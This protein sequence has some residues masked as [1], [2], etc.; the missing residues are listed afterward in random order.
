[1]NIIKVQIIVS[2]NHRASRGESFRKRRSSGELTSGAAS[3]A[4]PPLNFININVDDEI[5]VMLSLRD[6]HNADAA[7]QCFA[8][9]HNLN[10]LARSR[11]IASV[12]ICLAL[13]FSPLRRT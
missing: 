12:K 2:T 4:L 5:A 7:F 13:V 1:L 8:T 11:E 9:D 10:N 3:G 6:S